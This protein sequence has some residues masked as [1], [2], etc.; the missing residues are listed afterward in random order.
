MSSGVAIV[1]VWRAAIALTP[2]VY[3]VCQSTGCDAAR[4]ADAMARFTG[5]LEDITADPAE[6]SAGM[7]L[8]LGAPEGGISLVTDY[9]G[10]FE[11]RKLQWRLSR[12]PAAR[13]EDVDVMTM[14]FL[15]I[16]S[17]APAAW[18]DGTDLPAL[19]TKLDTL[20]TALKPNWV[21][22]THSDQY[23]WYADGPAFYALV[24]GNPIAQ[25]IGDNPAVRITEVD[26]PGT[27][28]VTQALPPQSAMSVTK[29][30]SARKH[31]GRFYIPIQ[32]P[33]AMD[34]TGLFSATQVTTVAAAV[35][36]FYNSCRASS[37]LPVV[38][39]IQKGERPKRPS[40]TLPAQPAKAYEI[41]SVQVDDISDTI[42]SRR[43]RSGINKTKTALT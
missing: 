34:A 13:T 24:S 5:P 8:Y 15:K 2:V 39:S 32:V 4:Y 28:S 17:G 18:V 30:T 23:R 3:R 43:Y 25:P 40:G 26:V 20:C 41:T 6:I 21:S 42:R 16:S 31:W 29:I 35:V 19:E 38:W 9:T 11:L 37:L 7:S 36:A 10:T 14:H 1:W 33:S 12:A 22:T 27:G